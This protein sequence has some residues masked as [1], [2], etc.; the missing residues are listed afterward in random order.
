M[1][2]RHRLGKGTQRELPALFLR[3][4]LTRVQHQAS[5]PPRSLEF[6]EPRTKPSTLG[7]VGYRSKDSSIDS[8]NC[9]GQQQVV[10]VSHITGR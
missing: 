10:G 6:Q 2:C 9:P 4:H 8:G 5:A 1:A 3:L 7:E